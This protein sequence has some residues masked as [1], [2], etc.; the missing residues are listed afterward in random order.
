MLAER[1]V[2]MDA[3]TVLQS[4]TAQRLQCSPR[5]ARVADL[6]GIHNRFQARWLGPSHTPGRGWLQWNVAEGAPADTWP[7]LEVRDKGRIAPGR[8]VHRVIP[9]DALALVETAPA[10]P[11]QFA[12]VV[13]EARHLGETTL[14]SVALADW[15]AVTFQ[16]TLS[17]LQQR[18]LAPSTRTTLARDLEQVYVMPVR[19]H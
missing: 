13:S 7:R 12:V 14:A 10:R 1:L 16:L 17:G 2:V 19:G 5:N 15:P 18:R 11:G 8:D 9:G 3:G 4:G 6:V